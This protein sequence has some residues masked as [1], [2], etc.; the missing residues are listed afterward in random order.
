MRKVIRQWSVASWFRLRESLIVSLIA[1]GTALICFPPSSWETQE[2]DSPVPQG[3]QLRAAVGREIFRGWIVL[4][5]L[6]L[7]QEVCHGD[8]LMLIY[9]LIVL[10]QESDI[11]QHK[12]L[13]PHCMPYPALGLLPNP[14]AGAAE[15]GFV[16]T[17]ISQTPQLFVPHS[18]VDVPLTPGAFQQ[19]PSVSVFGINH[20]IRYLSCSTWSSH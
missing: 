14:R 12:L 5:A 3:D 20:S 11:L 8:I 6:Q 1:R 7:C 15:R 4:L 18:T 17:I 9:A 19:Q 13:P 16:S 2:R 10:K